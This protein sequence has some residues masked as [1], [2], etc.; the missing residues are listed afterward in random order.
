MYFGGGS[1]AGA[2]LV[3]L[4]WPLEVDG[5]LPWLL[6]DEDCVL[7]LVSTTLLRPDELCLEDLISL[8]PPSSWLANEGAYSN[9]RDWK[10]IL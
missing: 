6:G 5:W 8:N 1:F 10:S 4:W 3:A 7:K 2:L 9:F